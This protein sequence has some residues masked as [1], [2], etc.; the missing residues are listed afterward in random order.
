MDL[1]CPQHGD[2]H[3]VRRVTGLERQGT[4]RTTGKHGTTGLAVNGGTVGVFGAAGEF[5]STTTSNLIEQMRPAPPYKEIFHGR[6]EFGPAE[7][8]RSLIGYAFAFGIGGGSLYVALRYPPSKWVML[9]VAAVFLGAAVVSVPITISYLR[10]NRRIRRGLPQALE[11]RSLGY[12]CARC[13]GVF[14]PVGSK[15]AACE[16][17]TG[18]LLSV[19]DFQRLIWSC[20]G[21][22]DLWRP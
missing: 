19:E 5:S 16:V 11:L 21:Y 15:A 2:M 10:Y 4:Q 22:G 20:G 13:D 8:V 6:A 9:V 18:E 3:D 1:V 12:Y 7:I 17:P 14:F